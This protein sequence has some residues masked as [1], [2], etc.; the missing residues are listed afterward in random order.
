MRA[1]RFVLIAQATASV[2]LAAGSASGGLLAEAITGNDATAAA[3]LGALVLGAGLSAPAGAAVMTR[4]GRLP[5]LLT[6]YLTGMLGS[7]LVVVA[8]AAGSLSWLLVGSGFLGAANTAV[9][10]SRYVVADLS[11]PNHRGRAISA[12]LVTITA[13]AV[14][15]PNLLDPTSRMAEALG[16]P[17]PAGLY[18][19]AILVFLAAPML[20]IGPMRTLPT[21]V[22]RRSR[23]RPAGAT[24]TASVWVRSLPNPMPA[25]AVLTSA[26]MTMVAVM[27]V[28]PVHLD[29]Q[30]RGLGLVG[31][32]VS[33]HVAAMYIASPLL[34]RIC[35]RRGPSR[36]ATAGAVLFCFAGVTPLMLGTDHLAAMTV[37]L[38]LLGIA[39]NIQVVAGSVML[40]RGVPRPQRPRLEARGELAM[41]L[42]AAA[43]GL[44]FAGLLTAAGG[45]TLLALATTPLHLGVLLL[46]R[47]RSSALSPTPDPVSQTA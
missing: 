16:L 8:A 5:A 31:A 28:A 1:R 40:I 39:W 41:S 24:P 36:L 7:A 18:L 17:A 13:G 14:V 44:W 6:G 15:G 34:G 29:S 12:S 20:L 22:S 43:G 32:M 25:I 11:P 26:N 3:P 33:L 46:L 23:E 9:T 19:V 10:L 37:L 4:V 38:V 47:I 45:I 35:D 27:A 21:P 30:G 42:G 2:G